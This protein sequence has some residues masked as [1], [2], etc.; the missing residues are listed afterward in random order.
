M[1]TS[2]TNE[3]LTNVLSIEYPRRTTFEI[4][5]AELIGSEGSND[6]LL[7]GIRIFNEGSQFVKNEQL[8][9]TDYWKLQEIASS[10]GCENLSGS[11]NQQTLAGK[12]GRCIIKIIPI[13]DSMK[14]QVHIKVIKYI[15]L[16][17]IQKRIG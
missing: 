4:I 17:T 14:N 9:L 6:Y 2:K 5:R 13:K 3:I 12:Q 16:N 8:F 7:L 10:I 1:S 11:I 15:P